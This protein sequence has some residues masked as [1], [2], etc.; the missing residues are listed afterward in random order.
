[1]LR[2][3]CA[4]CTVANAMRIVILLILAATAMA[5]SRS[6]RLAD[7]TWKDAAAALT[8]DAVIMIPLGAQSKEHG[9]HL[10]LSND[11]LM[12]EYLSTEVMKRIA[13]V[14]APT[15]N[16]GF[17]PAFVE[18]PGSASLSLNTARDVVIEL[19][20]G[21]A[22]FGPR[23]FY[24]LNTG[25]STRRPLQAAAD[26]LAKD[27]ITMRFTDIGK[28]SEA[29]EKEITQEK[30]GTHADEIETSEMLYI[31]PD[32]VNMKLAAADYPQGSP[33]QWKDAQAPHYS[34]SGVYGD[35][36]L[37]TRAKGERI[38]KA[39][40]EYIVREIEALRTH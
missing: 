6:V 25:V 34:P 18:Y 5:Q 8:P 4:C 38:A 16:Y 21:F 19:C 27:G 3:S 13:V 26:E 31:A 30:E 9:P 20:R 12:A 40:I 17:Y 32:S 36:T 22:H 28:A 7:L 15:L 33:F 2:S 29:V 11:W 24:V 23:R 35:A 1:M 39:Q 10:K 14:T 37:A